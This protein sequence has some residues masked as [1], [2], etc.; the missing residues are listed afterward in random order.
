MREGVANG[1]SRAHLYAH[2]CQSRWCAC[3]PACQSGCL[4]VVV[5]AHQSQFPCW[6]LLICASKWIFIAMFCNVLPAGDGDGD[7]DGII[8]STH[9]PQNVP[10]THTHTHTNAQACSTLGLFFHFSVQKFAN[11]AVICVFMLPAR[12]NS[13]RSLFPLSP[14]C[15]LA[16]RLIGKACISNS[17]SSRS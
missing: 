15:Q 17:I 11:F 13:T 2:M 14:P 8:N 12:G 16:T 6:F 1:R 3:L 10:V 5:V 4:P 9:M 7:G